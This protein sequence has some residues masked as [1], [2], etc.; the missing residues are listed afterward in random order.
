MVV[1]K[2][3]DQ[4]GAD[5]LFEKDMDN[6]KFDLYT[7]LKGQPRKCVKSVVFRTPWTRLS[8]KNHRPIEWLM[9][10]FVL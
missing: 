3:Y 7:C 9:N 1:G 8:R 4:R 5:D 2:S 6:K 10:F